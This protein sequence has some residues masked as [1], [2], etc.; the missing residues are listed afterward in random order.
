MKFEKREAHLK[1]QSRRDDLAEIEKNL[2]EHPFPP[3]LVIETTSVCGR[4][5]LQHK[6]A[7]SSSK[8]RNPPCLFS[9]QINAHTLNFIIKLNFMENG[10]CTSV[11][12]ESSKLKI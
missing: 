2:K 9:I 1:N 4:K 12:H 3:Q 6:Q 5:N 8:P 11:Q 7:S 10:N